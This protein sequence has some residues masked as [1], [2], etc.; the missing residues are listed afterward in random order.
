MLVK[1][2]WLEKNLYVKK[3]SF[4][5]WKQEVEDVQAKCPTTI[6]ST[7]TKLDVIAETL[8]DLGVWVGCPFFKL[9]PAE[10][11]ASIFF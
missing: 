10:S 11:D 5:A 7:D 6:I 8:H 9:S 4:Q 1:G 2:T 3:D